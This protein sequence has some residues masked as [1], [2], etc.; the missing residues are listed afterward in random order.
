MP[1]K[2]NRKVTT[3]IAKSQGLV[4][5]LLSFREEGSREMLLVGFRLKIM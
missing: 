1:E 2:G 5:Q 4:N 3:P